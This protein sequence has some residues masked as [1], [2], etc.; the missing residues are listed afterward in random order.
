VT[1]GIWFGTG[2]QRYRPGVNTQVTYRLKKV[3]HGQ[4]LFFSYLYREMR[5]QLGPLVIETIP[6]EGVS[7]KRGRE[8]S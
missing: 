8:T 2:S 7:S 6:G 1:W 3:M 4:D 5:S